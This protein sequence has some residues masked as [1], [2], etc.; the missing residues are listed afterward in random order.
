MSML[1]DGLAFI[2]IQSKTKFSSFSIYIASSGRTTGFVTFT[3]SNML[4]KEGSKLYLTQNKYPQDS[5]G[6]VKNF[7]RL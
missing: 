1:S 3:N 2:L 4:I 5:L 6:F 7:T